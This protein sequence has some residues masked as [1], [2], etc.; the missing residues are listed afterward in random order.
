MRKT[1]AVNGKVLNPV[2]ELPDDWTGAE[3]E[4]QAPAGSTLYDE[5]SGASEGDAYDG[6]TLIK[7]IQLSNVITYSEFES[8][9][10]DVEAD[11]VVDYV[12]NIAAMKRSVNRAI[13]RNSVNLSSA[14]TLAF[15]EA[16]VTAS[17]ITEIRKNEILAGSEGA[18]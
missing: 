2:I 16:L 1:I 8:R 5:V 13:A 6:T 11:A 18:E 3:G 17:V 4:W 14:N 10:T 7:N 12:D 9:F 15:M